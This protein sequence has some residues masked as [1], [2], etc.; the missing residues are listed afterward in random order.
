LYIVDAGTAS[1]GSLPIDSNSAALDGGGIYQSSGSLSLDSVSLSS[2]TAGGNGS[3]VLAQGTVGQAGPLTLTGNDYYQDSGAY[4]GG[5]SPFGVGGTLTLAGGSF[6]ATS[7]VTSLSGDFV[8]G[9]G[10]TFAANSGEFGFNGSTTQNL[11]L[12]SNVAFYDLTVGNSVILVETSS[13]DNASVSHDLTNNGTIRKA[14]P[15]TGTG[16]KT[17]GLTGVAVNVTVRSGLTN[18]SVDRIDSNS[19]NG[20][21]SPA[22]GTNTG[23]YWLITP[24]GAGF[25]LDLT[26]PH[27]YPVDDANTQVCEWT[28]GPGFGWDCARSASNATTVTR[29][30]ITSLS[31]WA[32][33]YLV[34]PTAITLRSFEAQP[35]RGGMEVGL[36]ALFVVLALL[37]LL[38]RK[39]ARERVESN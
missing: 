19:T 25:T 39:W 35:E 31:E 9:S 36:V 11:S 14:Q 3:G 32:V 4:N 5:S 2:N 26:L 30:G 37:A 18:L 16:A 10:V 38:V 12:S 17:F 20:T 23:R 27:S 21:G 29:N 15:I 34:G 8:V 28:A 13:S 6:D 22:S 7:D 24:T 1:L 33:G